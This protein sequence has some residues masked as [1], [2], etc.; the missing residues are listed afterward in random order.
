MHNVHVDGVWEEITSQQIMNRTMTCW[1]LCE[2]TQM[3][4]NLSL[5]CI[6]TEKVA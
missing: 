6:S 3:Y 4:S 2:N 1:K 5:Q